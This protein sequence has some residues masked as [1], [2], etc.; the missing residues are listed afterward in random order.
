MAFSLRGGP[1]RLTKEVCFG[2]V[3]WFEQTFFF[4]SQYFQ[5]LFCFKTFSPTSCI[6]LLRRFPACRNDSADRESVIPYETT[7]Q[8]RFQ[9]CLF[10]TT[11]FPKQKHPEFHNSRAFV[12]RNYILM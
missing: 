9:V 4:L 8:V 7:K 10:G 11:S 12:Y 5:G 6:I 1:K 2:K 3:I